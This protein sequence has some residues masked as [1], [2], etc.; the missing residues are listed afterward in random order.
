M[1][2][3]KYLDQKELQCALSDGDEDAFE[4]VFREYYVLLLNYAN[5]ILNDREAARDLVQEVFYYLWNNHTK[6]CITISL[7]AYLFR[8][9]YTACIDYLRHKKI[10]IKF[11]DKVLQDF[12]FNEI[13]QTPDAELELIDSDIRQLVLT[14]AAK[15]PEKCRE[16]FLLTKIEG[17]S[18]KETAEQLRIS[19][20]TV[21]NQMTIALSRLRKEMEWL[22]LLIVMIL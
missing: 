18:N 17:K 2:V 6:L 9:V 12:Y 3:K 4:C 20:K 7:K 5:R 21:E 16:I 14:A 11:A 19:V 10:E 15:L 13:I 22:L 1:T 8:T